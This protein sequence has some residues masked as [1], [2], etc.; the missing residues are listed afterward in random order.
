MS[1]VRQH[2]QFRRDVLQAWVYIAERNIPAAD[3]W[4][5]AI[6]NAAR[7]LGKV[8]SLGHPRDDLPDVLRALPV[9]SYVVVYRFENDVVELLRL[10]HGACD[11]TRIFPKE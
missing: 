1:R 11:F 5:A 7:S 4:R 8:P 3:R 2:V 9:G 6:E 10:I